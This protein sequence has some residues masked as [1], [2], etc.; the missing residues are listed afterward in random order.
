MATSDN[1]LLVKRKCAKPVD[2][3]GPCLGHIEMFFYDLKTK[4][5]QTFFWRGC[6]GNDNR[7]STKEDC[8]AECG[9]E[10]LCTTDT[11]YNCKYIHVGIIFGN[12]VTLLATHVCTLPVKEGPC[13][14]EQPRWY[15]DYEAHK[16]KQFVYTGCL[17]NANNFKTKEECESMCPNE[18]K[19][20]LLHAVSIHIQEYGLIRFLKQSFIRSRPNHL[21]ASVSK[22]FQVVR[23]IY[24]QQIVLILNKLLT[25]K[26]LGEEFSD[27]NNDEEDEDHCQKQECQKQTWRG[28]YND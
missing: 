6:G 3:G 1:E 8:E 26:K 2:E 12:L 16:C 21:R 11:V 14:N 5:C 13:K 17:G 20:F 15:H 22:I 7:F 10:E 24:K 27:G 18:Y 23:A 9:K 28:K 4:K 25:N 19:S